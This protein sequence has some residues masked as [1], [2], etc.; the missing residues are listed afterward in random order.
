MRALIIV[1]TL[2]NSVA[3][4]KSVEVPSAVTITEISKPTFET[5]IVKYEITC[6]Q[7]DEAK[8]EYC[9]PKKVQGDLWVI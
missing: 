2:L 4:G 9:R 6:I 1:I 8:L 3:Y 5:T 7:G